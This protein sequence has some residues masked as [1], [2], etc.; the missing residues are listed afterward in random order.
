MTKIC[1]FDRESQLE[2]NL[3][4][5]MKMINWIYRE[6][7]NVIPVQLIDGCYF[8]HG[9]PAFN[10]SSANSALEMI[11]EVERDSTNEPR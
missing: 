4:S 6:Y 3:T 8:I 1:N 9:R 2:V 5:A 11:S 10:V 7:H